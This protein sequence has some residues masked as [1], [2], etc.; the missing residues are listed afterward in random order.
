MTRSPRRPQYCR[1]Q[2]YHQLHVWERAHAFAVEIRR[3][4]GQFPPSFSELRSQIIRAGESIPSNLVEG[5]GAAT[6]REFARFVDISIKSTAEV[7]YRLELARDHS[8]LVPETWE[9]L[10]SE[11]V[12]IRKML[13]GL[14]KKLLAAGAASRH[15]RPGAER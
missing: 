12:Q 13:H 7:Q 14:R 8:L 10:T 9:E 15:R 5:C 11:V 6:R 2:D 1:M 3:V 4:A